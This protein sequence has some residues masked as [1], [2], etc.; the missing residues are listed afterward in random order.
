MIK[1]REGE[2]DLECEQLTFPDSA[3]PMLVPEIRNGRITSFPA[4][5]GS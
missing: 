1:E 4:A 3:L 5:F 2:H